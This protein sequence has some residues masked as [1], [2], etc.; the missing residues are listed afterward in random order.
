MRLVPGGHFLVIEEYDRDFVQNSAAKV[1]ISGIT[2][3]EEYLPWIVVSAGADVDVERLK[4]GDL[5]LAQKSHV[6]TIR[7][8]GNTFYYV[9][10]EFCIKFLED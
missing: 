6:N 4:T 7:C 5:I 3:E 8:H 10:E 9:D 1:L 2:T